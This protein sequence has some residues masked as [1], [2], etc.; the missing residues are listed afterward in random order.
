MKFC[1]VCFFKVD[2]ICLFLIIKITYSLRIWLRWLGATVWPHRELMFCVTVVVRASGECLCLPLLFST[3]EFFFCCSQLLYSI[4]IK[5]GTWYNSSANNLSPIVT[6]SVCSDWVV[7]KNGLNEATNS[8]MNSKTIGCVSA[9]KG[10]YSGIFIYIP[11]VKKYAGMLFLQRW[12][13]PWK[14]FSFSVWHL[15]TI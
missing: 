15:I 10:Q 7:I 5:L 2:L 8:R 13:S 1:C 12:S 4:W 3:R 14:K 6:C 11:A 9:M